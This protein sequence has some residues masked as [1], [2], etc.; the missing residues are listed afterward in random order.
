MTL[1]C[2]KCGAPLERPDLKFCPACGTPASTALPVAHEDAIDQFSHHESVLQNYRSMFLVSETFS[3]SVAAMRLNDRGLV[4]L[5]AL[6]G[7][8]GL[9]VW[10]IITTLRARVVQFF[11]EHDEDGALMRYHQ[12]VEGVAHRAGFWFF[13]VAFPA[14]FAF[15]WLT[16]I[17]LAYGV[18]QIG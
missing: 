9:V 3:V 4:L 10:I 16:L 15:F 14:M 12:L 17:L 6:F 8:S 7:I 5:F 18:V 11:E 1:P 13:T 2:R